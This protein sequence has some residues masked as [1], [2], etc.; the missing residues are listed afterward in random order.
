MLVI[1]YKQVSSGGPRFY[2]V[3]YGVVNPLNFTITQMNPFGEEVDLEDD[4]LLVFRIYAKATPSSNTTT[5]SYFNYIA[6]KNALYPIKDPEQTLPTDERFRFYWG[7]DYF[8]P[9]MYGSCEDVTPTAIPIIPGKAAPASILNVPI[10]YQSRTFKY[11]Q[12]AKG[13]VRLDVMYIAPDNRSSRYPTNLMRANALPRSCPANATG[14]LKKCWRIASYMPPTINNPHQSDTSDENLDKKC[15]KTVTK[16]VQAN[17]TYNCG[18]SSRPRTCTA[19]EPITVK[20]E[21][22]DPACN[23][24]EPNP[25]NECNANMAFRFSGYFSQMMASLG[26]ANKYSGTED[27]GF[28]DLNMV[29]VAATLKYEGII[30]YAQGSVVLG[31]NAES[32][33]VGSNTSVSL[34]NPAIRMGGAAPILYENY[35][36]WKTQRS[37]KDNK[38]LGYGCIPCRF[39]VGKG[40]TYNLKSTT[41]ALPLDQDSILAPRQ[42]IYKFVLSTEKDTCV[43]GTE[44]KVRYYGSSQC[45]NPDPGTVK[46]YFCK[47]GNLGEV[48]CESGGDS[49]FGGNI[50]GE[51][52]V[53]LCAGS[54]FGTKYVS[55]SWSPI[56]V[57]VQGKGIE[58]SRDNSEAVEFDINGDGFK[59][60]ID[61]P[62]ATERVAFLVRPAKDG[63]IHSVKQLFG[64]DEKENGFKALAEFDSDKNGH[65]NSMDKKYHK[66]RLWFDRDRDGISQEHELEGLKENGV[67][68]IRLAYNTRKLGGIQGKTLV[69][70]FYSTIY[71]R[72]F[73]IIDV[74][75]RS[76]LSRDSVR[77]N[78]SNSPQSR[79]DI[80]TTFK[81]INKK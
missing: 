18:S 50:A 38:A 4:D 23:I 64:D 71:K 19:T 57:D 68:S 54:G 40:K 37:A 33:G 53:P 32:G 44:V 14:A 9:F 11:S 20:T 77:P 30:P 79:A 56:V 48:N 47:S 73:N 15:H 42:P 13:L 60:W 81:E 29:E 1:A 72:Y 10:C 70:E 52:T 17:Y 35:S 49:G 75:F 2:P 34:D 80:T 76:Y 8:V 22:Y 62:L 6:L 58:I 67:G 45:D 43:T 51:F 55:A 28:S 31:Q 59:T 41:T 3:F 21:V 25:Q 16:Q 46:E 24:L 7:V 65:I 5:W 74:Y 78:M 63:K 27:V 61:W 26:C 69:S 39:G 36:Y 66:L 12:Y